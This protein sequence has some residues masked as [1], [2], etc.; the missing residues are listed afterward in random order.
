MAENLD[1]DQEQVI[2]CRRLAAGIF[3]SE[4]PCR[5]YETVRTLHEPCVPQ[6][7]HP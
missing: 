1:R 4:T 6:A 2:Q 3:D 7:E 5:L